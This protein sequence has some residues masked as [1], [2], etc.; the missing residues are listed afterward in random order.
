MHIRF[1]GQSCFI[2]NHSVWVCSVWVCLVCCVSPGRSQTTIKPNTDVIT[3]RVVAGDQPAARVM[4]GLLRTGYNNYVSDRTF[5]KVATN[6]EGRFRIEQV[7]AGSFSLSVNA[8][9]YVAEARP[10]FYVPSKP[11]LVSEGETVEVPD[12]GLTRGGVITGKVLDQAGKP[13]IEQHVNVWRLDQRGQKSNWHPS[14][15]G[16][17]MMT[18][19][20]GVYR[21]FGLAEGRYLISAG[22]E[23][24]LLVRGLPVKRTFYPDT[25]EEQQAKP[26]QVT[27]GSETKDIDIRL[28]TDSV[29]GHAVLVRVVDAET[30]APLGGV[31][32]LHGAMIGDRLGGGLLVVTDERGIARYEGISPGR[33]GIR[34]ESN[35]VTPSDY[36][37][38]PIIYELTDTDVEGLEIRAHKGATITG[39]AVVEG[40]TDPALLAKLTQYW[41]NA[42]LLPRASE[43]RATPS[44]FSK[45]ADFQFKPDGS[46]RLGGL[47]PGKVRFRVS[48]VLPTEYLDVIRVEVEGVPQPDGLEVS[49]GQE[50]RNVRLV[51]AYGQTTVR[52][53]VQIIGGTLPTGASLVA[54]AQRTDGQNFG[55]KFNHPVDARGRFAL[56]GVAAGEYELTL[57]AYPADTK[58]PPPGLPRTVK[59]RIIVPQTGEIA[60]N[61]TLDLTPTQ[62]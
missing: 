15:S 32:T 58:A 19:D 46:F 23:Q 42:S 17:V 35:V 21:V 50:V 44:Q 55:E 26:I 39:K 49:V 36:F 51:L 48:S 16:N 54:R 33:Y 18:D 47:P 60:V 22:L 53:Q 20:R 61:L 3:G 6:A 2:L 4:V 41:I 10:G 1:L 14:D 9:G 11:I 57:T 13:L 40:S 62:Q 24:Q 52:G 34:V 7:P 29:K 5:P 45:V 12:I 59:Q 8:P 28:I 30:G 43:N 31:L 38:D 37:S 56:E 25:T 27:L